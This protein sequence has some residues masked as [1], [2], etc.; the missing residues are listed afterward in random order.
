MAEMNKN[1]QTLEKEISY[2]DVQKIMQQV[3]PQKPTTPNVY[4]AKDIT[5]IRAFIYAFNCDDSG[6]GISPEALLA[7]CNR[8]GI[9]NP[10]PIISK[11]LSLYGINEDLEKDFKRMVARYKLEEPRLDID[12]DFFGPSET[13]KFRNESKPST[14]DFKETK[15]VSPL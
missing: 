5:Q 4:F 6:I 10:C 8:Y 2:K 1:N 7:G 9:D 12:P 15:I 3:I 11:R 14:H 13:L